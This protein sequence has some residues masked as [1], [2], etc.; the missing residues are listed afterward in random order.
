MSSLPDLFDYP[1]PSFLSATPGGSSKCSVPLSPSLR[2]NPAFIMPKPP[3]MK[4]N[5]RGVSWGHNQVQNANN[6]I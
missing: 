5:G 6:E 2:Q 1:P 4:E 3:T